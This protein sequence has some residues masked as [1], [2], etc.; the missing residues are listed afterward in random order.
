MSDKVY[1]NWT[2]ENWVTITLMAFVGV[3]I[4]GMIASAIR[5]YSGTAVLPGEGD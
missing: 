5:H 3:F 2:F 1:L 4:V